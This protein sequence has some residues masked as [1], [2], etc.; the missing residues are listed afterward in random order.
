M[1]RQGDVSASGR[2]VAFVSNAGNMVP[3]ETNGPGIFWRDTCLGVL[4][5][6]TPATLRADVSNTGQQPNS[7]ETTDFYPPISADGRLV[8]FASGDPNLTS[9]N[10]DA[11]CGLSGGGIQGACDGIYVRDTCVGAQTG[12]TPSTNLISLAND[13][14]TANCGDSGNLGGLTMSADGRFAAFG[15]IGTNFSP[16]DTFPACGWEDIFVRDTC[17]GVAGGC[18]PS[19]VRVSVANPNPYPGVS[20]N[21]PNSFSTI[22]A[23]GHY[24]VFVSSATNLLP[25]TPTNGHAIVY[26][27]KTGF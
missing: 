22:S 10:V 26:L 25:G 24:V 21:S 16:D 20:S 6:C 9:T 12:C 18:T 23:D 7:Y 15:S 14:S 17:F 5:G 13:G 19:T 8:A 3:N 11:N 2:F 4:S 1:S 27:A